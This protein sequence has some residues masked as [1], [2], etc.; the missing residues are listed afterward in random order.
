MERQIGYKM[1][2][3]EPIHCLN[4][5]NTAISQNQFFENFKM[6]KLSSPRVFNIFERGFH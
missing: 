6:Q 4:H 3:L 5:M 2:A 1:A